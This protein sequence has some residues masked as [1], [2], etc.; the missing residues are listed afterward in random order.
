MYKDGSVR[1]YESVKWSTTNL[2]VK[3]QPNQHSIVQVSNG[4][5]SRREDGGK[6]KLYTRV[7]VSD[8]KCSSNSNGA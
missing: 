3:P 4:W 8:R 7:S 2:K 5:E 1:M 6:D